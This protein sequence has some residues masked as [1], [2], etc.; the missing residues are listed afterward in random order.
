MNEKRYFLHAAGEICACEHAWESPS[1]ANTHRA[2]Q[3]AR[4]FFGRGAA[5]EE[6]ASCPPDASLPVRP[7]EELPG[8]FGCRHDRGRQERSFGLVQGAGSQG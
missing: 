8:S 1:A 5:Q 2:N 3:I 6:A 4:R 7:A